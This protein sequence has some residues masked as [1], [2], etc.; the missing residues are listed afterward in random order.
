MNSKSRKILAGALSIAM[1]LTLVVGFAASASADTYAYS[2]NLTVGSTGAD[3]T[4]LQSTL[5]AAGFLKVAPTGYFGSLTKAALG[6]W[7]ASVGISPAAGYFGAISRAYLATMTTG[8]VSTVPGCTPGAMFSSTTGQSCMT[9]GSP[10]SPTNPTL[11]NTDGSLTVSSSSYVS[12]GTTLKKGESKDVIA[13]RLQAINGKVSVNRFDVH[14]NLRPWLYFSQVVLHDSAGNVIATK[15]ITGP[16]DVTEV[17][18]GTDYLVRFDNFSFVVAP[19][20]NVDLVVKTTVLAST[21]KLTSN[22]SVTV[23]VPNG[24][25]R[26]INGRGFTDTPSS[27]ATNNILLSATGSVAGIYTRISPNTPAQ[28]IVTTSTSQPTNNV[29]LGTYGLQSQNNSSTINGLTFQVNQSNTTN[30]VAAQ[31]SNFRLTVGGQT[32]GANAV[33]AGSTNASSTVTFTNLTIP[34]TQ[35]TWTDL[36][37]QADIAQSVSSVTASTTLLAVGINGVD[38]NYNNPTIV[39]GNVTGNDVQ[40]LSAGVAVSNPTASYTLSGGTSGSKSAGVSFGFTLTN[41]SNQDVYISKIPAVALGTS[42][43]GSA[44]SPVAASSTLTYVTASPDQYAADTGS[45]PT[46]G[47]FVIP[48]GASRTFTYTGSVDNTGGTPGLR[49]FKI[50]QINFGTTTTSPAAS[51]INFGLS[52]LVV[53]PNL[54]A[55]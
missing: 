3:V 36:T 30:T 9:P 35:D 49:V 15:A 14:F 42:T 23:S 18:V 26:T 46:S 51:S 31:F 37:L 4:A 25:I 52:N 41:T 6:A 1:V 11:D 32:Y 48:S 7:Q 33:T 29:V 12:T 20:A 13:V 5:Y 38:A 10:T 22:Q 8:P 24:S 19:G 55:S 21:D 39:G 45:V 17:T 34:L 16:S 40:F 2:R 43:A 47:V 27:T 50:T 28:R 53:T 54:S 44:G